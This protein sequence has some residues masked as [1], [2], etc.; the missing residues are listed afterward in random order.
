[1]ALDEQFMNYRQDIDGLRAIAIIAVL[2]FHLGVPGF[3]GGFVGVDVFFVISGYLIS[4][5]IGDSMAAGEFTFRRFYIKRIRRLM[6][7]FLVMLFCAFGLAYVLSGPG[8]MLT[9]GKTSA[10]T[11]LFGSNWYFL[12]LQGYFDPTLETNPLLHTWSLGIEEQ[13][14]LFWPMVLFAFKDELVNRSWKFKRLLFG[15]LALSLLLSIFLAI[16]GSA[17]QSFFNSAGRVWELLLGAVAGLGLIR[18]PV[19][20]ILLRFLSLACLV[21]VFVVYTGKLAYPGLAATVPTIATFLLLSIEPK[22]G[23]VSGR[24]LAS[25]PFRFVGKISYSLYLWHWPIL[26]YVK[27][28]IPE[29]SGPQKLYIA[30]ASVILAT[31]STYALENPIRHYRVV[32][33]DGAFVAVAGVLIAAFSYLAYRVI[34]SNGMPERFAGLS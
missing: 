13:F 32:K 16:K 30:L 12:T 7:S 25:P 15:L 9:F 1:M 34:A 18:T 23:D 31:T 3:S 22:D 33:N 29:L 10:T 2:L 11:L 27:A 8:D 19:Q 14:Y 17:Q 5:W 24:L 20:G 28:I 26:V 6:P 4:R 21:V